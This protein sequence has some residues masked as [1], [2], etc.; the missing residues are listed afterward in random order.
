MTT[1]IPLCID[2]CPE[3]QRAQTALRKHLTRVWPTRRVPLAPQALAACVSYQDLELDLSQELPSPQVQSLVLFLPND[4][5]PHL[6]A[7]AQQTPRVR[8]QPDLD[9]REQTAYVS[10]EVV[11]SD[12]KP[13]AVWVQARKLL[14]MLRGNQALT[15]QASLP[16]VLVSG[17]DVLLAPD[18]TPGADWLRAAEA[19]V[20]AASTPPQ[21]SEQA[22]QAAQAKAD[23]YSNR[24][25]LW[26]R[27]DVPQGGQRLRVCWAPVQGMFNAQRLPTGQ[28]V[29]AAQATAHLQAA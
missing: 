8:V 16:L 17:A 22:L 23:K 24:P 27:Y 13:Q 7:M 29:P 4:F 28:T 20:L 18:W 14:Q 25:W 1:V 6:S 11:G 21:A 15:G 5:Q 12:L 9:L 19:A 2:S 3:L 26:M 10:W